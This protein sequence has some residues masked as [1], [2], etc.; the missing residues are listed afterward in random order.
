MKNTLT[1]YTS[2]SDD[3]EPFSAFAGRTKYPT[4]RSSEAGKLHQHHY[5]HAKSPAEM[6]RPM[7]LACQTT[8]FQSSFFKVNSVRVKRTVEGQRKLFKHG[9]KVSLKDF[10]ISTDPW[11][12]LASDRPS[13]CHHIKGAGHTAEECRSLQAE[14]KRAAR[15]ARATSANST[16]PIHFCSTCGRGVLAQIGP[17]SHLRTQRT[18]ST[19][20]KMSWSSSAT[21]DEH[22]LV[23][24]CTRFCT[25]SNSTVSGFV[26][27]T[28]SNSLRFYFFHSGKRIKKYS[29]SLPNLRIDKVRLVS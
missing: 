4:P 3:F 29:D 26:V 18:S 17:I 25:S 9:L 13:W 6:S 2:I 8:A 16:A 20:N 21:K 12:S 22:C 1:T 15:D 19:A 10:K 14:Q 28:L 7:F 5:H 24:D 27:H 11:G 23:R